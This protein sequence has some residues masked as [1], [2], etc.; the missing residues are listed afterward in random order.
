MIEVNI[1]QCS[2][3]ITCILLLLIVKPRYMEHVYMFLLL[4]EIMYLFNLI[5]EIALL[6]ARNNYAIKTVVH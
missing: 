5:Y 2:S 1:L 6:F 4:I 3:E